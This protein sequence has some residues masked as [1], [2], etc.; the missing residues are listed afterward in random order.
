MKLGMDHMAEIT[1]EKLRFLRQMGVEAILANPDVRDTSDAGS[2]SFADLV[3]LKTRIQAHGLEM[4]GISA[5][6]EWL[7][8]YKWMLGLPGR[9]QQIEGWQRTIRNMGAAGIPLFV[10]N[11]HVMRF[12]RTSDHAPVRGGAL[13]TSFD[14]ELVKNAPLLTAGHRDVWDLVPES[15]RRPIG[16]EEMW[17]N[18]RYFLEAVVP[19]AEEAGVR[20]A[21]HPDDPQVPQIGGVAR[22]MRSP[23]AFRRLI[24]MVPSKNNGM[25]LCA[26]CFAEM[27]ADVPAEIRYFGERGRIFW[28]HFRNITG[29]TERFYEDFPDQGQ[30]DMFAVMKACRDAG[31]DGHLAP[32][33]TIRVEGDS[34]WGHR[35]WAYALGFTRAMMMAVQDG[36]PAAAA[37]S[38][39][40]R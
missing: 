34:A 6:I 3:H 38:R 10:Y 13:S 40:R 31:Y 28:M 24:E 33:H 36:R 27:G 39:P 9:D 11:I 12:Y 5:N 17:Q 37:R 30:T 26:G 18:L 22:I 21:M 32:D 2:Y 19:V 25:L 16:D 7:W 8:Q 15:H 23:D 29:T 14:A 4:A 35:Y 1:D 20:L